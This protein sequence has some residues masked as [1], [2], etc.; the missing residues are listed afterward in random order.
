MDT[1]RT[2]L[3]GNGAITMKLKTRIPLQA[4]LQSIQSDITRFQAYITYLEGLPSV[5]RREACMQR[6]ITYLG[7]VS[8]FAFD[9]RDSVFIGLMSDLDGTQYILPVLRPS[10]ILGSSRGGE[11]KV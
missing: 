10:H 11:R 7:E 6:H 2:F 4:S 5:C 9:W 8:S 1:K 3:L